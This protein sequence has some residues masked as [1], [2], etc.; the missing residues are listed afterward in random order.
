MT[1][2]LNQQATAVSLQLTDYIFYWQAAQSPG[3]RKGAVSTLSAY[4]AAL[5]GATFSGAL[6]LSGGVN[7]VDGSAAASAGMVGQYT[8][9]SRAPGSA[10]P[11]T[12]GAISDVTSLSLTAG[13]WMVWANVSVAGTGGTLLSAV[14]G[15]IN[16][17]S[18]TNPGNTTASSARTFSSAIMSADRFSVGTLRIL[19]SS[20]VT[21]YLSAQATFTGTASSY[22]I[23]AARRVR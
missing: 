4:Y 8:T 1:N 20:T 11:L 9:A 12:S 14:N 3:T 2:T 17:T 6:T 18:V 5:T 7:G 10:L 21:A 22:G 13:E 16:T 19:T 23:I 15:W